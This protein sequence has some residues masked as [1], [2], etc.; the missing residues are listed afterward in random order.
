MSAKRGAVNVEQFY[1]ELKFLNFEDFVSPFQAK[2]THP[3]FFLQQ[4]PDREKPFSRSIVPTN[5]AGE[6]FLI[7]ILST[8][9]E[10]GV[11]ADTEWNGA[12]LS[13]LP[14]FQKTFIFGIS[15]S[16]LVKADRG[17]LFTDN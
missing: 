4:K 9:T 7:L 2:A 5:N 15:E 17:I 16:L 6:D 12:K 10:S 14:R 3:L 1:K 11:K 8:S 13:R